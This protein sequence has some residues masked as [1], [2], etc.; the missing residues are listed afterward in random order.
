MAVARFRFA[1]AHMFGF[2]N[3]EVFHSHPLAARGLGPYGAFRD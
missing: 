1:W 2:P 3:D